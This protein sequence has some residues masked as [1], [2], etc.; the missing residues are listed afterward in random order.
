MKMDDKHM[1]ATHFCLEL[2]GKKT[3]IMIALMK[4]TNKVAFGKVNQH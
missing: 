2:D 1:K 3:D 4:L